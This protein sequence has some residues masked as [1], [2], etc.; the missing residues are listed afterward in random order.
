V[1][2]AA[3]F[4]FEAVGGRRENVM[5]LPGIDELPSPG[6]GLEQVALFVDVYD[7]AVCFLNVWVS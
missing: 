3:G 1:E 6:S 7:P 5:R 2:P 4:V